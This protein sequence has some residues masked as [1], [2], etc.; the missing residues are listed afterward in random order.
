MGFAG[1][2]SVLPGGY[3][4]TGRRP[5][6]RLEPRAAGRISTPPRCLHVE[7]A[8]RIGDAGARATRRIASSSHAF[9]VMFL[10]PAFDFDAAGGGR[11]TTRST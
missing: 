11:S 9:Q 10:F 7:P 5:R 2:R 1:R 6:L 3:G 4:R 8:D